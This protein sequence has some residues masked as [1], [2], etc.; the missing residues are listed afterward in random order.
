M[1][2][3]RLVGVSHLGLSR[4]QTRPKGYSSKVKVL[5]Y[6]QTICPLPPYPK[7]LSILLI[8]ARP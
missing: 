5:K 3:S 7:E 8:V 2:R 1:G 6:S 4:E